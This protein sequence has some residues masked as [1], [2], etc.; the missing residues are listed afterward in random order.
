M[1]TTEVSDGEMNGWPK[2]QTNEELQR[3][4]QLD[5]SWR[6]VRGGVL[7]NYIELAERCKAS[8]QQT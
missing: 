2:R 3:S 6:A 1:E 5:R 7:S 4:R 8:R